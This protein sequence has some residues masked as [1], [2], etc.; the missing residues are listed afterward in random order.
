MLVVWV[1]SACLSRSRT[2]ASGEKVLYP[3]WQGMQY[4]RNLFAGR[5][6]LEPLDNAG[7]LSGAA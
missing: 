4:M 1:C 7:E 6:K 2:V 3:A 5:A